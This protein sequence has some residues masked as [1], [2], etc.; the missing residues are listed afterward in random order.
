MKT[1]T[2]TM[3][4]SLKRRRSRRTQAEKRKRGKL[5]KKADLMEKM[6]SKV[7]K[8]ASQKAWKS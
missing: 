7:Q 5:N 2:D 1:I 4:I 3:G 8:R 6:V